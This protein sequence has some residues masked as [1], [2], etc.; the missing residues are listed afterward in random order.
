MVV[1]LAL[2]GTVVPLLPR[3][4][5]ISGYKEPENGETCIKNDTFWPQ[6]GHCTHELTAAAVICIG[7]AIAC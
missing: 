4:G 6:R 7:P 5:N 1:C 2:F 3:L